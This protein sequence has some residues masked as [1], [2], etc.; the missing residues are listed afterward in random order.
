MTSETLTFLGTTNQIDIEVATNFISVGLASV[1]NADLKGSVFADDSSLIVNGV[2]GTLAYTATT[3][4]DWNGTAPTTV[5]EAID[6]LAA[7]VKT[8][9]GGTGA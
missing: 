3:P 4:T 1:V 6:R 7:L 8:L 5:G 9:N 2:D